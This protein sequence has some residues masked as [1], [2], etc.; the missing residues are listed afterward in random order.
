M[1]RRAASP[2]QSETEVD[3]FDSLYPG[4]ADHGGQDPSAGLDFDIDGILN[5]ADDDG[6]AEFIARTQA[7]S[8]RKNSNV[9]G[10]SVKK[11]G[12]FQAM[13]MFHMDLVSF[14]V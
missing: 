11:G 2:A 6:D 14:S 5:G 13:G 4:E 7:A 8:N 10:K 9:K 1:P 12:G 3:I